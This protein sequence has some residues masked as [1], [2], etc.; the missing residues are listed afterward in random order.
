MVNCQ[1][2]AWEWFAKHYRR[3]GSRQRS[4]VSVATV[5]VCSA[6]LE[7]AYLRVCQALVSLSHVSVSCLRLLV[8]SDGL[9]T[10]ECVTTETRHLDRLG[11]LGEFEKDSNECVFE[12]CLT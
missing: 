6:S 2:I 8:F 4:F 5:S 9:P 10:N 12:V 3:Y 11:Q 1:S 7:I